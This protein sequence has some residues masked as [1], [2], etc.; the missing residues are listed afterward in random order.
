MEISDDIIKFYKLKKKY[1]NK[2]SKKKNSILLNTNLSSTKKKELIKSMNI[3]CINCN[4]DG[5]TIFIITN[6]LLSATCNSK[7]KCKLNINIKKDIQ[8]NVRDEYYKL[9]NR[10]SE[11]K[12]TIIKIKNDT[13]NNIITNEQAVE[14]FSNYE[15]E[16]KDLERKKNILL[17]KYKTVISN[18]DNNIKLQD[19][20]NNFQSQINEIK[21]NIIKF[22]EKNNDSYIK[23]VIEIYNNILNNITNDIRSIKYVYYNIEC[24]DNTNLP[25]NDN[26]YKLVSDNYNIGS[27]YQSNI[28]S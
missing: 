28:Y 17:N 13:I 16:Y 20:N 4:N 3:K 19:L 5:G 22:N 8:Y 12:L 15:N 14:L 24:L 23:N 26:N 1:D 7:K 11:I 9:L 21:I 6:K 27:L 18:N 2:I 25:C 10:F